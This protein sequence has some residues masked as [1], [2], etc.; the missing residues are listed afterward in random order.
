MEVRP[1]DLL[2]IYGPIDRIEE[3]DQRKR[4]RRGEIAH[5]EAIQELE[6]V[7]EEQ[8]SSEE[9]CAPTTEGDTVTEESEDKG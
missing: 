3:L 8:R 6:E 1:G 5:Q 9:E 4:G 2:V 7:I